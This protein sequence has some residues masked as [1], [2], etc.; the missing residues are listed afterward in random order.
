MKRSLLLITAVLLSAS[1]N[2]AEEVALEGPTALE[3]NITTQAPPT[4]VLIPSLMQDNQTAS[5]TNTLHLTKP[6]NELIGVTLPASSFGLISENTNEVPSETGAVPATEQESFDSK[7]AFLMEIG[8]KFTDEGDFAEAERAYL[9]A[10][11]KNPKKPETRFALSALYLRMG[12]HKESADLLLGLQNDFPGHP[13]VHNNLAWIYATSPTMKNN[14]LALHHARETLLSNPWDYRGWDTLAEAYY[15]GGD[16]EKALRSSDL[17]IE[18]LN[19][20]G[21][22][23]KDIESYTARKMKIQRAQE[24]F[25]QLSGDSKK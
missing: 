6:D 23:D 19:A 15:I 24:A 18:L 22:P 17:A 9:R 10:Y 11:E 20:A 2:R 3:V 8:S 14:K 25:K 1:W 4:K 21:D 5:Q 7:L 13:F 16:Y 12:R